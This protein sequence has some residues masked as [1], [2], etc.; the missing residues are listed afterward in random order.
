MHLLLGMAAALCGAYVPTVEAVTPIGPGRNSISG[1]CG[2]LVGRRADGAAI[3]V[4]AAHV[5][6][7]APHAR[8]AL[9][10]GR[11]FWATEYHHAA[12]HA[13]GRKC[14]KCGRV[15]GPHGLPDVSVLIV[16]GCAP[17][18]L[19]TPIAE[20]PPVNGDT[21]KL[22]GRTSGARSGRLTG[23]TSGGMLIVRAPSRSGD[24]GGPALDGAGAVVGVC[25]AT[26]PGAGVSY[27]TPIGPV[28]AFVRGTAAGA[29]PAPSNAKKPAL[30]VL[31][32]DP[33]WFACPACDRLQRH[34]DRADVPYRV[35]YVGRRSGYRSFPLVRY[36]GRVYGPRAVDYVLRRLGLPPVGQ[37]REPRP[38]AGR[39]GQA[40]RPPSRFH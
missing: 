32:P 20:R 2:V 38:R 25:T 33:E 23:R 6:G 36:K 37:S 16:P 27:I 26:D 34:L 22:L 14:E 13:A 29:K 8:V 21:I 3:V 17:D 1:G 31:A 28:V 12:G 40:W 10:D 35:E 18:A 11:K 7:A 15:H 9:A 30:T 19:A 24:S 4:T 5:L 39:G